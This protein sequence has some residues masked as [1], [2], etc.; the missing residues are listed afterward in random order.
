MYDYF[1]MLL[2]VIKI[3]MNEV[4]ILFE[5]EMIIKMLVVVM[6]E[7]NDDSAN[8]DVSHLEDE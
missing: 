7:I 2:T 6:I 4:V 5:I 8:G 3:L 1:S